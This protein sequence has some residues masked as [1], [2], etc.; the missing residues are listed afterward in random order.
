MS[1]DYGCQSINILAHNFINA[2]LQKTNKQK[3]SKQACLN[4]TLSMNYDTQVNLCDVNFRNGVLLTHTT[5]W[6]Y[7]LTE[8]KHSVIANL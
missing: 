5:N 2:L 4:I 7:I 6:F 3:T 8:S 1:S